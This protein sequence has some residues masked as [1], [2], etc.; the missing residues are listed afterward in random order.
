MLDKN[1]DI[2]FGDFGISTS[3]S[4]CL[5]FTIGTDGYRSPEI[6]AREEYTY[7]ADIW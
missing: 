7:S 4:V 3:S 1:E 2:K 5:T 6:I